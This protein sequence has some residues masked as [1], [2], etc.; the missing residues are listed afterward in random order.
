MFT[1]TTT[2]RNNTTS[3]RNNRIQLAAFAGAFTIVGVACSG[4]AGS[5]GDSAGAGELGTVREVVVEETVN[6]GVDG[7][8]GSAMPGVL[9]PGVWIRTVSHRW[10]LD[11]L[12]GDR[13]QEA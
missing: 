10:R 12:V 1:T 4:G 9:V 13:R 5:N 7:D 8:R 2:N 6:A 11:D 3:A